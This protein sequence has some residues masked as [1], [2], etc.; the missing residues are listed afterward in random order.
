MSEIDDFIA[1]L[2]AGF[3][4]LIRRESDGYVAQI[5]S[6]S[7]HIEVR[8]PSPVLAVVSLRLELQRLA[9]DQLAEPLPATAADPPAQERPVRQGNPPSVDFVELLQRIETDT[10]LHFPNIGTAVGRVLLLCRLRAAYFHK[11]IHEERDSQLVSDIAA[12]STT[13][14]RMI[15]EEIMRAERGAEAVDQ[16][17]RRHIDKFLLDYPSIIEPYGAGVF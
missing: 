13:Y 10:G 15:E 9:M 7:Q 4:F 11:L 2:P 12:C 6:A 5:G 16:R 14:V 17:V 8:A 3:A 1:T